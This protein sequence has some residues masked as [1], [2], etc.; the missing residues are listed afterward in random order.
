MNRAPGIELV[1]ILDLR[2]RVS[3]LGSRLHPRPR[4]RHRL[5]QLVDQRVA[6]DAFRLRVE[7][8]QH[9]VAQHRVRA[10]ARMSSKLT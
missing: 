7:V 5:E 3:D 8:G 6:R 10:A 1:A 4:H 9:A 2:S